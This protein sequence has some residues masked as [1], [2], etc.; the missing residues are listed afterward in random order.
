MFVEVPP[1]SFKMINPNY[2]KEGVRIFRRAIYLRKHGFKKYKGNAK[3]I[4]TQIV[5]D[6]WNKEYFKTSNGHFCQFW[7]RD[8]G[9]CTEPLIK[10]GYKKEVKKTL[11]YALDVFSKYNKVTTTISENNVPY[12]FPYYAPD[13]LAYL[14]R[15]LRISNSIDLIKKKKE[16]LNREINKFYDVVI[17]KDTGLVRKDKLFS[18][19]KDFAVRKSSCY[20]NS[21]A[22][23]LSDE[24]RKIKILE[25]PLK[26]YNFRKNIKDNFWI[27]G[28][29]ID[30]LSGNYFITGDANIF[31]FYFEIFTEKEMLRSALEKIQ[32]M[33]LDKPFPLRYY[34]HIQ[35]EQKMILL[36]KII[37]N[38]ERDTVWWHIGAI[39]ISLVKKINKE[40]ARFYINQYKH[41]IEKYRNYLEL[42][43]PDSTPYKNLFYCTDESMLWASMYL[44][45]L[46]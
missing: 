31:P 28:Y 40:K 16:F 17:E 1:G 22:A 41:I 14:V 24:L 30:D 21:I 9:F 8:F 43:N 42:F 12:D 27:N 34:N 35:K 37:K 46:H 32:S 11:Q 44:D 18:S 26:E 6:C 15:S 45:L 23:M 38:Y 13:S 19:I 33:E 7:T 25:N 4:C 39:Y 5:R 29:F 36:D 20:D 2:L 3:E 10:I